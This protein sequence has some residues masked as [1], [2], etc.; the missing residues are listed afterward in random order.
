MITGTEADLGI[1]PRTMDMLFKSIH[2]KLYPDMDFKPLRCRDYIRLTK[3][4][5]RE[6]IAV[7]NSILRLMKEVRQNFLYSTQYM[8]IHTF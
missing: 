1:L 6:E 2:G 5:V 7:K 4:Q 8:C 3:E